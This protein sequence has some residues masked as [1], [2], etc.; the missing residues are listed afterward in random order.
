MKNDN[1][2]FMTF[3]NS[4]DEHFNQF[5]LSIGL[6]KYSFCWL[7]CVSNVM[8]HFLIFCTWHLPTSWTSSLTFLF[9]VNLTELSHFV[10]LDFFSVWIRENYFQRRIRDFFHCIELI[11]HIYMIRLHLLFNCIFNSQDS[12]N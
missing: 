2:I 5:S 12:K 10:F 6:G 7:Y 1:R 4:A 11:L 9:F 8:W 3:W